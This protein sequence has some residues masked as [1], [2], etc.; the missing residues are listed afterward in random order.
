MASERVNCDLH[1]TRNYIT[2]SA[3]K[4]KRDIWLREFGAVGSNSP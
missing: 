4:Q 1:R 3:G 2:H